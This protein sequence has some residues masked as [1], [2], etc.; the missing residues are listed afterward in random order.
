MDPT[1]KPRIGII[2]FGMGNLFSVQLAWVRAEVVAEI[3]TSGKDLINF[4]CLVLPGVGAFGN[5]MEIL[6]R[7]D[8]VQPIIEYA[9]SGKKLM[10][11]C[12]GMQLLMSESQEFGLHKGLNI[13]NGSVSRLEQSTTGIRRF[14]VPHVGWSRI[15]SI[16]REDKS[17]PWINTPLEDISTGQFMYF[18]HSYYPLPEDESVI[19]S[20]TTYGDMKFC[21]TLQINNVFACQYH[22]ERSGVHGL[23]I[24]RN[25]VRQLMK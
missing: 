13:I 3:V 6:H 14:K 16:G 20:T 23:R 5:A 12:L 22:P 11:I 24:Y 8:L 9:S 25:F 18:V 21:S 19:L 4:D 7:M 15:D 17:D 2:D 1:N 10:G